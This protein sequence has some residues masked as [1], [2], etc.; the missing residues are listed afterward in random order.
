MRF[1]FIDL[2]STLQECNARGHSCATSASSYVY[3]TLLCMRITAIHMIPVNCL[4]MSEGLQSDRSCSCG[5]LKDQS[6]HYNES[7][8][9]RSLH[10]K[11][12]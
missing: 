2:S 4:Q 7:A 9:Y 1:K 11:P 10:Y 6:M 8:T 3:Y 5:A 12:I